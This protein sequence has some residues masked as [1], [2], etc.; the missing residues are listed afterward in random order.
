MSLTWSVTVNVLL[1]KLLRNLHPET[2]RGDGPRNVEYVMNIRSDQEDDTD[3]RPKVLGHW[4][5][6]PHLHLV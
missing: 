4:L 2:A 1:A 6:A 5:C 3:I